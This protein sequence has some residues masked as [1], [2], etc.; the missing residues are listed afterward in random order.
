M[1]IKNVVDSAFFYVIIRATEGK[2]MRI[3]VGQLCV[4]LIT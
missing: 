3:F 4:N 2:Y 1:L